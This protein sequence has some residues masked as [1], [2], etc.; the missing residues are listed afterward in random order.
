MARHV[1]DNCGLTT[2]AISS[3]IASVPRPFAVAPLWTTVREKS[4]LM[5]D[6][7]TCFWELFPPV[8]RHRKWAGM[9][10]GTH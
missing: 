8:D 2:L 1:S 9:P 7:R 5:V 10:A 6:S 4:S 3:G